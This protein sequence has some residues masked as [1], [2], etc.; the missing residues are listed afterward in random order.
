M[1]DSLLALDK[2]A[3]LGTQGTWQRSVGGSRSSPL[4][5]LPKL[6]LELLSPPCRGFIFTPSA[7]TKMLFM[8]SSLSV[9]GIGDRDL[10]TAFLLCSDAALVIT[11]EQA[12]ASGL[13]RETLGGCMPSEFVF[14]GPETWSIPNALDLACPMPTTIQEAMDAKSGS[15]MTA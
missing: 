5:L 3:M 4:P 13:R 2:R 10:P 1:L 6:V 12:F 11:N 15:K 14:T 8:H 7:V 9:R